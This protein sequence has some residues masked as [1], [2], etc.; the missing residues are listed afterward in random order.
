MTLLTN[1]KVVINVVI[2]PDFLR[3]EV[4]D[5]SRIEFRHDLWVRDRYHFWSCLPLIA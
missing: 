4:G 3:F 1:Q 2:A 5:G